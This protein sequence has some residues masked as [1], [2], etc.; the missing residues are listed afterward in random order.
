MG[1]VRQV[2]KLRGGIMKKQ[3]IKI[4]DLSKWFIEKKGGES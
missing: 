3:E 2:V 4:E 1:E